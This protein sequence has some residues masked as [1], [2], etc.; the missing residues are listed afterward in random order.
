MGPLLLWDH[1]AAATSLSIDTQLDNDALKAEN[2]SVEDVYRD[3]ARARDLFTEDLEAGVNLDQANR[4]MHSRLNPMFTQL[5]G[6]VQTFFAFAEYG[7][8]KDLVHLK[9]ALSVFYSL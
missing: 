7:T 8:L 5:Y 4:N 6:S 9:N 3:S 2:R 1:E